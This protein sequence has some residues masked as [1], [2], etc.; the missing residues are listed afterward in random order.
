MNT[1][2]IKQK[3]CDRHLFNYINNYFDVNGLNAQLKDRDY[4]SES[5]A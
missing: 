4:H 3:K 1:T 5:N 2:N